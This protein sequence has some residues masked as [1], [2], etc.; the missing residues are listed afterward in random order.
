MI[1]SYLKEYNQYIIPKLYDAVYLIKKNVAVNPIQIDNGEAYI[2]QIL[3]FEQYAIRGFKATNITLEES[4]TLDERYRFTHNI[5]FTLDGYYNYD[6]ISGEYYVIIG[7]KN[8][9]YWC[10]NP[11]IAAKLSYTYTLGTNRDET[12]VTLGTVSNHP[13]LHV[14]NFRYDME[15]ICPSYKYESL[16]ALRM[17]DA[18]YCLRDGDDVMSTNDGFKDVYFIKDSLTFTEQFDGDYISD[19]I[20]FNIGFTNYK[21]SW[22]YNLLEFLDNT[23]SA[24]LMSTSGKYMLCGFGRGMIPSYTINGS[25]NE[26]SNS[27]TITLTN[28]YDDPSH[29]FVLTDVDAN[30][31]TTNYHYNYTEEYAECVDQGRARYLLKKE[32]DGTS[33]FSGCYQCLKGYEDYFKSIGL[34]I[35][36]TFNETEEFG[37]S[38]CGEDI[39]NFYTDIP[40]ELYII[41]NVQIHYKIK[42]N[43]SW[44]IES[45]SP[46]L[47]VTPSS[48]MYDDSDECHDI[49]ITSNAEGEVDATLTINYCGGNKRYINVHINQIGNTDCFENGG[50]YTIDANGGVIEL[51]TECCIKDANGTSGIDVTHTRNSVTV[52]VPTKWD[53]GDATYVVNVHMCDGTHAIL[54]ITQKSPYIEWEEVVGEYVCGDCK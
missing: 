52:T 54:L 30:E 39:C 6:D 36:G 46:Y 51:S 34:C 38:T 15:Y 43:S 3:T 22:H 40:S 17:N 26:S 35:K 33:H 44:E 20:E 41:S 27:I 28:R 49:V 50:K 12:V 23:Y 11:Q 5:S 8:D 53:V 4:E 9:E 45:D 29:S 37:K 13:L 25:S 24:I 32:M 48:Y 16:R 2:S 18:R 14:V 7:T 47:K 31:T 10:L 1:S 19:T 21:P 42:S